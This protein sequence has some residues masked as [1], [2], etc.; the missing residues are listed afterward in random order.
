MGHALMYPGARKEGELEKGKKSEG[1]FRKRLL[2]GGSSAQ[3]PWGARIKK[4]GSS[5]ELN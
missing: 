4:R 2:G 3:R 5:Q 1:E